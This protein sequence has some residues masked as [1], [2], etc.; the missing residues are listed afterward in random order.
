MSGRRQHCSL[1][2]SEAL[3]PGIDFGR[4]PLAN[5][6]AKTQEEATSGWSANLHQLDVVVCLW[7]GHSQIGY[8]VDSA[9]LFNDYAYATGTSK[10]TLDHLMDEALYVS[11]WYKKN[12][13]LALD[14][15]SFV[16][17]IGC[18]DGSML[19]IWRRWG[20]RVLGVDP[21]ASKLKAHDVETVDKFFWGGL[22][23]EIRQSHGAADV[24]IANNVFAHVPD[25]LDVA[26]GV[27]DVLADGGIFVFEV[28]YLMD[29]VEAPLFDTIYHEHMSYHAVKPLALMLD[30]LGMPIVAAARLKSQRGRG[31]LRVIACKGP[32]RSIDCDKARDLMVDEAQEG[33]WGQAFWSKLHGEVVMAGDAARAWIES[34]SRLGDRVVGYGAAAKLTTLMYAFKLSRGHIEY[35][36][37]DSKW[38]QGLFT[39]GSGIPIVAP[40]KMAKDQ[41]GACVLFA[42]NFAESI[43]MKNH[44][45]NGRWVLPLPEL[46][47]I[48]K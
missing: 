39:P 27:K 22:G 28:S 4:T 1:C 31:S 42:W 17:E 13:G 37:D 30:L 36:V 5:A 41:P 3:V 12:V 33:L 24:V 48:S 20:T 11:D 34:L 14:G 7:C 44:W 16:L 43:V 19:E 40:S 2:R 35:I 46:Q 45:Y 8:L 18:N 29:M 21:A 47:E 10:V 9:A 23:K 38:K 26:E 6:Y 25:V 32:G 15:K